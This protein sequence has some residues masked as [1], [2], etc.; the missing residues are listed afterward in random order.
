MLNTIASL[1]SIIGIPLTLLGL[2]FAVREA[3]KS[4]N[5]SEAAAQATERIKNQFLM[6][7]LSAQFAEV[8]TI[9]QEVKRF[10]RYHSFAAVPDR[11]SSARQILIII[12]ETYQNLDQDSKKG[13]QNAVAYL[14]VAE[15]RVE[16]T[17]RQKGDGSELGDIGLSLSQHIDIVQGISATLKNMATKG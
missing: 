10:L 4:K 13:F 14:L 8:I 11:L 3:R 15:G 1:A 5:A 6:V 9:L 17:I 7:D 12:K 16:E 2:F